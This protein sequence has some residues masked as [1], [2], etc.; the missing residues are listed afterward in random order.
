MDAYRGLFFESTVEFISAARCVE[1]VSCA[2]GAPRSGEAGTQRAADRVR[3][4]GGGSRSA[5][6]NLP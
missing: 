2:A 4:P 3:G 1:A 6:I 5:S